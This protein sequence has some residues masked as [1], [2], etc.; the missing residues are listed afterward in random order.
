MW[1]KARPTAFSPETFWSSAQAGYPPGIVKKSGKRR[2]RYIAYIDSTFL[3][4]A[5]KPIATGRIYH[6][7]LMCCPAGGTIFCGWGLRRENG[8]RRIFAALAEA[9]PQGYGADLL[10]KCYM[11]ELLVMLNRACFSEDEPEEAL[12]NPKIQCIVEFINTHLDGDLNLELLSARFGLS[13]YHM[14]REF[15]RC[16]GLS[17]HQYV[18]KK[19]LLEARAALRQ[20]Q[21]AAQAFALSGFSDYSHFSRAFRETFG[22]SPREYRMKV[23]EGSFSMKVLLSNRLT[24][25]LPKGKNPRS[26]YVTGFLFRKN[27][28]SSLSAN[29]P[30]RRPM[31]HLPCPEL[32]RAASS[33]AVLIADENGALRG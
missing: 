21:T 32:L 20:G 9:N 5:K 31:P 7:A 12:C 11:I 27:E 25:Y 19:R 24:N 30:L 15:K 17:L 8:R 14:T 6:G 23:K 10:K 29:I 22:M 33:L 2:D 3:E 16:L 1:W 26:S 13:K 28:A 18:L 4:E